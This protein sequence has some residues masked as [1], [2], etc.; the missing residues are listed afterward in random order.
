MA[1][2]NKESVFRTCVKQRR[3]CDRQTGPA[4]IGAS[5]FRGSH[6]RHI[7]ASWRRAMPSVVA[8]I[9]PDG[10]VAWGRGAIHRPTHFG[11]AKTSDTL[12]GYRCRSPKRKLQQG[13]LWPAQWVAIA[14]DLAGLTL[15]RRSNRGTNSAG[16]KTLSTPTPFPLGLHCYF[17]I[18]SGSK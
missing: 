2:R 16:H 10:S 14:K 6:R 7:L 8:T 9:R 13:K 17:T 15:K 1:G 3:R 5:A 18:E 11:R 4:K 12:T